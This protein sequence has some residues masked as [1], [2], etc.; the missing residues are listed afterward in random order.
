MY[1]KNHAHHFLKRVTWDPPW[2]TKNRHLLETVSWRFWIHDFWEVQKKWLSERSKHFEQQY[3]IRAECQRREARRWEEKTPKCTRLSC[4]LAATFH[5]SSN[6]DRIFYPKRFRMGNSIQ[7]GFFQKTPSDRIF[8]PKRFR[9][10][11]SIRRGFLA[12][13]VG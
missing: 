10:E 7:Q 11:N 1:D 13:Y 4:I 9:I 12:N 2:D 5:S 6:P 3:P 8:Y